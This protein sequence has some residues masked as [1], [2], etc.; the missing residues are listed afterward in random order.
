MNLRNTCDTHVI[1][2]KHHLI[3][4]KPTQ[5]YISPVCASSKPY[6]EYFF[7]DIYSVWDSRNDKMFCFFHNHETKMFP[8]KKHHI[9]GLFLF[10]VFLTQFASRRKHFC[11]LPIDILMHTISRILL[12]LRYSLTTHL[13]YYSSICSSSLWQSCWY[14]ILAAS[15]SILL[16]YLHLLTIL[17]NNIHALMGRRHPV[18]L[19]K[20]YEWLTE[21][22]C[23]R[24]INPSLFHLV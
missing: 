16:S 10:S 1:A 19:K 8:K 6:V 14:I 20:L 7:A 5:A 18:I 15:N 23:S 9:Y 21:R 24:Q 11:Y 4:L 13:N 2:I 12:D 3:L 17:L 22:R